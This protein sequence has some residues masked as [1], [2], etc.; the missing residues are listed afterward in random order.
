MTDAIDESIERLRAIGTASFA[1]G[2]QLGIRDEASRLYAARDA[3]E[4]MQRALEFIIAADDA[5]MALNV[6]MERARLALCI[7]MEETGAPKIQSEFH[8]ASV[9]KGAAVAR[10]TDPDAIPPAYM[11]QPAPVIDK[12][13]VLRALKAGEPV[14]GAAM[15]NSPPH[16]RIS[17]R[18][19]TR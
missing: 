9:A 6:M 14:P 18:K 16:L 2:T 17:T 4:V 7:A 3:I 1:D 15:S 8:V 19:Q 5:Q 12:A 11:R 10:I 13:A